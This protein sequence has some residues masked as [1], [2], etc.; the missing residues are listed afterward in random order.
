MR[1]FFYTTTSFVAS[2]VTYCSRWNFYYLRQKYP[3]L[4]FLGEILTDT[5]NNKMQYCQMQPTPPDGSFP[6]ASN[7]CCMLQYELAYDAHISDI[8]Y[9]SIQLIGLL[10]IDYNVPKH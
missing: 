8:P 4:T 2:S 5:T 1:I 7:R 9:S 6:L 3:Y 10:G